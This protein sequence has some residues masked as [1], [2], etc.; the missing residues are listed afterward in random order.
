MRN[1]GIVLAELAG[2]RGMTR[3]E[4]ARAADI[5]NSA[6]GQ[7]FNGKVEYPHLHVVYRIARALGVT[8]D[9]VMFLADPNHG[10][11]EKPAAA[12]EESPARRAVELF[13]RNPTNESYVA[14]CKAMMDVIPK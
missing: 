11:L 2:E 8:L 14:A 3:A 1:I 13:F 7:L 12:G 9:D 4:I 5:S 6:A 10:S